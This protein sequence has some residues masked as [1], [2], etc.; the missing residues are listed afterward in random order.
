MA[1]LSGMLLFPCDAGRNFIWYIIEVYHVTV[2]HRGAVTAPH[3]WHTMQNGNQLEVSVARLQDMTS[4]YWLGSCRS[5]WLTKNTANTVFLRILMQEQSISYTLGF[6]DPHNWV[7]LQY[8]Y[9]YMYVYIFLR[10]YWDICE[11][12]KRSFST[13]NNTFFVCLSEI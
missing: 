2:I 4:C 6:T 12:T 9:I 5:L 11:H 13:A 10:A 1:T 8:T 3:N 7:S